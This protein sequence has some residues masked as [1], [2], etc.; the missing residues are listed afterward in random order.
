MPEYTSTVSP[1]KAALAALWMDVNSR[2]DPTQCVFDALQ[3]PA[4]VPF[5]SCDIDLELPAN[6]EFPVYVAV[7]ECVPAAR[8][9][10][11]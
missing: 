3:L 10:V 6:V 8:L 4:V 1:G 2:P 5:T 9:A 7:I 11:T